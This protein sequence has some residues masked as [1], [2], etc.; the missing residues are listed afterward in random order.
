MDLLWIEATNQWDPEAM[1]DWQ[2]IGSGNLL[3]LG[4]ERTPIH[5]VL[6]AVEFEGQKYQV[7]QELFATVLAG[8]TPNL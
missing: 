7:A 5:G 6:P 8:A 2:R 3:Y 4:S 1:T